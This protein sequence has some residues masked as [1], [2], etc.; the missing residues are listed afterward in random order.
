MFLIRL[1][2][3]VG[4][5]SPIMFGG[6]LEMSHHYS[7]SHT[8][9]H[10]LLLTLAQSGCLLP[11]FCREEPPLIFECNHACSCWKTCKNRVVQN[12]LRYPLFGH[13]WHLLHDLMFFNKRTNSHLI[14]M[15]CF[16]TLPGPDSSSSGPVKRAGGSGLCRTFHREPLCASMSCCLKRLTAS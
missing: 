10:V 7:C 14:L 12:G 6:L 1:Y 11:E 16:K 5:E 2:T 8:Q 13:S 9:G 4:R 3:I 15:T